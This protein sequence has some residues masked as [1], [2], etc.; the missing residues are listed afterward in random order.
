M[1]L[2]TKQEYFD[3]I[4]HLH[5][6]LYAFGEKVDDITEHPWFRPPMESIGLVYELSGM[7][8]HEDLLTA[9]SPF[10]NEKVNRFLHI[11]QEQED[12]RK[13][14]EISRFYVH[15]HGACIGGRCVGSGALN[16]LF[17]MTY[18]MEQELGTNY[19]NRFLEYLFCADWGNLFASITLL[20]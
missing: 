19:H 6:E 2:K 12:L 14:L 8:E 16:S 7:D 5:T 17:A 4:K 11:H 3:S 1:P 15:K 20:L 13:R 18:E 10:V 9:Y